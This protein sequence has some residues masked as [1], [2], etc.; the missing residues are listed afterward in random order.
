MIND[1]DNSENR[2]ICKTV[3]NF[4]NNHTYL[5]LYITYLSILIKMNTLNK[6]I[7]ITCIK[8]YSPSKIFWH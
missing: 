2:K 5:F 7:R 3:N 6:Y 8:V 4:F 1:V